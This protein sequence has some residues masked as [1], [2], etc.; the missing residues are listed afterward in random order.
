MVFDLDDARTP[1]EALRRLAEHAR[2][3]RLQLAMTRQELAERSGV[4]FATL[5]K[6]E[7]TGRIALA[8]YLK[9]QLVLGGLDAVLAA[10]RPPEAEYR[11]IDEVVRANRRPP[12]RRRGRRGDNR[13]GSQPGARGGG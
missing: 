4:P 10:A 1:E 11:S 7:Q 6:F 9:L 12:A 5:R 3:R 2:E 8:S 13:H